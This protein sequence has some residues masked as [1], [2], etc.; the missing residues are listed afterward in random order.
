MKK[1]ISIILAAVLLLSF[2]ACGGSKVP[3]GFS[4]QSYECAKQAYELVKDYNEGKISDQ[5]AIDK[6]KKIYEN[7]NAL[8]FADL[9]EDERS[10]ADAKRGTITINMLAFQV[11]ITAGSET[12][13]IETTL[14]DLIK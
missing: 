14:K 1:A 10:L 2:A 4:E 5:D 11:A 12:A 7:A 9:K 3:H 8:S 6:A 13:T